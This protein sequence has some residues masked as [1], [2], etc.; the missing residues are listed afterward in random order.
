MPGFARAA[1]TGDL[2]CDGIALA[3]VAREVGTPVHVYSAALI[4]DRYRRLEAAFADYPH[5]LHYALKA[6]ATLGVVRHLRALGARADANSLGEIEVARRAGFAPGDVVFTGV[7]KTP[8][9]IRRAVALG[10]HAINVESPGELDRIA[11]AARG[12]PHPVRVAVRLNPD[13]DAETHPHIT[14]GRSETKFG[15]SVDEARAMIRRL[16]TE[17]AV[18]VV[19]LHAHAGSQITKAE[20]LARVAAVVADLACELLAQGVPLEHLDLGGGLGVAY[21]ADQPALSEAAYARA[22]LPAVRRTGLTLVLEPGR[23][24]VAPAGVI[25]T[26]VVDVKRKA[27]GGWFVIVDA[28]MTDL[29]RPALYGAWHDIEPVRP[30]AGE[31]LL[32]DIVGPVCETSDTLGAERLLPPV[33]IGDLLVIRDTGA[34]GAVMASN[35]NRRPMAAEVLIVEDGGPARPVVVRRRQSIDDILQWDT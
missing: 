22:L 6:N 5:Q 24:L 2:A 17:P 13:V 26:A 19:G 11:A 18:R 31:T 23:W 4:A 30:R 33:D 9:E 27:G 14:T 3:A 32:A 20:P 28:G 34:Y 15:V 8:D 7:G 10:L 21:A 25:V 12:R 1:P 35:Y 29:L 16:A